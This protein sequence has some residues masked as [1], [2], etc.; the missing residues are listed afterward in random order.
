MPRTAPE[1]GPLSRLTARFVSARP[2]ELRALWL[3]F[4]YHFLVLTSYYI[5]RPIRD[6]MAVAGGVENIPLL[7][8]GTLV[9]TLLVQ[10]LFALLVA[11]FPR[12][13][14]VPWTYHFFGLNLLV[15]FLLL[16]TLDPGQGIWIGRV[17]YVWVAVFNLFI[18][19]VFWAFM[20][21]IFGEAQS[22]RLFGFI[23]AGG[24]T[25]AILGSSI[26]AF[27]AVPLGPINL[28]IASGLILELAVLCVLVLGRIQAEL[29][30][31]AR[32][33]P[34][35]D[36]PAFQ[37][38]PA[39]GASADEAV[40]GGSAF[41]GITHALR[42]PYLLA[43]AGFIILF[44]I[45]S[46]FLYI[47]QAELVGRAFADRAARTAFF[48]KVDLATNVL[49]FFGQVYLYA[50]LMR[51]LG[52]PR[53]LALLPI[54][55]VIGFGALALA[56]TLGVLVVFN[57]LRRAGNFAVARPTREVLY[58]VIPRE[59]KYKA[60][61]FIDTFVYRLGDQLGAWGQA[62]LGL[63]GLGVAG[64][65]LVA[66]PLNLIWLGLALWLGW[67]QVRISRAR[68]ARAE[69]APAAP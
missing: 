56:P 64:I 63:L 18:T 50:R 21:D 61:S 17:F 43:I 34:P 2:E 66:V 28:L 45:G 4:V 68:A 38:A 12:R 29:E 24:S 37:A 8:T 30:T 33:A 22:K 52:V 31:D 48:A 51:W 55:S 62:G 1:P 26:T 20:V 14:F 67:Q 19:S 10:P 40:I 60:K 54:L 59:D 5:L 39:R 9:A 42:N 47:Q 57:V 16:R 44:T 53:M 36:A 3:A 13:R 35:R 7:W 65:A 46:S 49:T 41:A 58:T 27:L 15:F 6:E 11:R 69:A 23:A 25:G 32:A